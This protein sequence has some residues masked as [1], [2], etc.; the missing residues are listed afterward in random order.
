[1]QSWTLP[2]VPGSWYGP[3][4]VYVLTGR[5]T[6][7]GAE[8]VAYCLQNRKR[9]I[10]IGERTGGG[11]HLSAGIPLPGGFGLSLPTGRAV[12]P[13]TGTNWEGTGV[14]PDVEVPEAEALV[15]A[16]AAAL[17]HMLETFGDTGSRPDRAL[18]EEAR[19]TLAE[20]ERPASTT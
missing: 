4:P 11:A 3:R 9:A 20:L 12:D 19:R 1:M 17:R 18:L 2:Y 8:A 10:V 7:S 14:A 13:L 6:F 15:V 5:Q 16:Q